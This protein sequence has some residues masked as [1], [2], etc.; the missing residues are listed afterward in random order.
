MMSEYIKRPLEKHENIHH[1]NGIRDDNRIENLE[2]WCKK[3]P[4]GQRVKDKIKFYRE[5]LDFH[6]YDVNKRD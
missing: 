1:K 6:G 3:Q 2:L 4:A 5:Y